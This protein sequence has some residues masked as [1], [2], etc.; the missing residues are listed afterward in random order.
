MLLRSVQI[1]TIPASVKPS[2]RG[3]A[4][5]RKT[6]AC[7]GYVVDHIRPLCAGGLDRVSNMQWQTIV[8]GKKKD[9]LE[10]AECGSLK[11]KSRL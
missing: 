10:V 6:G 8:E 11:R 7:P 9:R 4:N 3:P 2:R 1:R 5:G